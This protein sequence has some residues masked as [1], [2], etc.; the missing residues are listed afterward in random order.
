MISSQYG[1]LHYQLGISC[2][3]KFMNKMKRNKFV[4]ELDRLHFVNTR[5]ITRTIRVKRYYAQSS[6]HYTFYKMIID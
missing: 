5:I 1:M 2:I 6:S 3:C 4:L